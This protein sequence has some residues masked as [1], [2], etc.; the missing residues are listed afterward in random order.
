MDHGKYCQMCLTLKGIRKSIC[1][2]R[3]IWECVNGDI[4]D[5]Y[6][7]DHINSVR[8]DNRIENIRC[9]TSAENRKYA[10]AKRADNIRSIAHKLR[11]NIKAI[12]ANDETETYCF[13]SKNQC[14]KFFNISSASVYLICEHKNNYKRANTIKGYFIFMYI[15]NIDNEN[16]IKIPDKR[17]NKIK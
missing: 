15:D 3:F 7:I 9:V 6:E 16:V 2:H 8:D 13:T 14:S 11:R 5:G 17:L 10:S 1:A 4:P 12:N